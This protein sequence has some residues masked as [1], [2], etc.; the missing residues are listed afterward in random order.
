MPD[1][2]R[3]SK[4]ARSTIRE[5]PRGFPRWPRDEVSS[6]GPLILKKKERIVGSTA[7]KRPC[8][9]LGEATLFLPTWSQLDM[10]QSIVSP[11]PALSSSCDRL[12]D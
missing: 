3:V 1:A 7:W 11:V 12:G 8:P 9:D 10:F 4:H 6:C 2:Y 5:E